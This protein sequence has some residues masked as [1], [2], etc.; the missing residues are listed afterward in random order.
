[1]VT[2]PDELVA[3]I[4]AAVSASPTDVPLR[5]H[6]A[7]LLSARGAHDD[8][9]HH[10]AA[11]LLAH[12]E[13]ESAR[14][15]M[16]R[17]LGDQPL[18]G[19]GPGASSQPYV[20]AVTAR[21]LGLGAVSRPSARRRPHEPAPA[22]PDVAPPPPEPPAP[23]PEPA[24]PEPEAADPDTWSIEGVDVTLDEV[25]GTQDALTRI[26]DALLGPLHSPDVRHLYRQALARGVLVY[27]PPGCGKR[28]L[29]QAVA[30]HLG[31]RFVEASMADVEEGRVDL[32]Q[33]FDDARQAARSGQV[34]LC[35]HTV[36]ALRARR[37]PSGVEALIGELE[38]IEEPAPGAS[39]L[40]VVA[41]TSEPWAVDPRLLHRG[42]LSRATLVMPPGVEARRRI[43]EREVRSAGAPE[44]SVTEV[45]LLTE[46]YSG[47]DLVRLV[48]DSAAQN[49]VELDRTGI[50]RPWTPEDLLVA[51]RSVPASTQSWWQRAA[52]LLDGEAAGV[53]TGLSAYLK[54]REQKAAS[55]R[56]S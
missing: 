24:P 38:Q 4:R 20:G 35:L 43:L 33:V 39:G 18:R 15:A 34:V 13:D 51:M 19:R 50:A 45:A 10:V 7:E 26:E 37:G 22:A 23:E 27:G 49:A 17:L 9:I 3:S 2:S 40:L 44:L 53:F 5:L 21:P 11:A 6:L 14:E 36:D 32:R 56:R 55:T 1:M 31:A 28:L 12:P 47:R 48:R 54:A 52:R 8:A 16:L 30:M 42:L 46:G 25:S 29:A 41:L